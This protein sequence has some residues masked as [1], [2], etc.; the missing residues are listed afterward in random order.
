MEI[1]TDRLLLREFEEDDW[2]AVLTYR[3]DPR[4]RVFQDTDHVSEDE[5][6]AMVRRIVESRAER[7][8]NW[9]YLAITLADTRELIGIVS[10]CRVHSRVPRGEAG[11]ELAPDHW[12]RGYATEAADALF[13]WAFAALGL[14]RVCALCSAEN[15]ASWRVMERV[16]MRRE[17]VLRQHERCRGRWCDEL[18]YGI[19]AHEWAA[20]EALEALAGAGSAFR[21]VA[22]AASGARGR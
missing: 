22:A 7:P 11:Y 21:P 4:F 10:V 20:R 3:S 6:R 9:Y 13:R 18:V 12:G 19:L 1:R 14:H 16:G 15:T 17:G 5:V 8:R 2:R